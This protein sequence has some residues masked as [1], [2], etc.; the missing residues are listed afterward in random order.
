MDTKK[1][2]A[3]VVVIIVIVAAVA[4]Y[5]ALG[6]G[7]N[8]NDSSSDAHAIDL[9]GVEASE[10]NVLNGTYSISRNLVLVTDGEAT[11]NVAAFLSWIM[12]EEGQNILGEE[13]VKLT[14]FETEIE[15]SESGTTSIT[16]GGS[17]SLSE[18]AEKL[19]DA[20]MDKYPFMKISIQG[21]GSG[22]GES[23]C[24]SGEFQIG[25]LSRDLSAE[26]ASQGL[27]AHQIGQDGVAVIANVAGVDGLTTEQV[28]QIFSGEITNW[29][30]VGGPDQQIL[31]VI[32]E[33]GSGTRDCFDSA[34]EKIDEDF[35][36]TQN[37]VTCQSTGL[38]IQNVQNTAGSIGYI[39]IG[40]LANLNPQPETAE[41]HAL[42]LDGVEASEDNVLNGTYSISRNLVLVTDG[43]ATGNVAAFLS[44]IMSEEGQNILGEEFVKLTEFETEIEPSESGTTSITMGG[45]TSLSETA[46]KLAD[47]YMDKYPFMKISIQGGGS[48]VG[49]SSCLSGEFQ[50]G[51]LS[52][53]LSAEGASQGLIAHQ[54][55]QDGVAVI[56]NVA[57]VDGLT[58]EQVAQIFSGEI[59]NWNQV[60]GPDQ[61][62]LVVIR[63]DGSGT[64]DCFDSAMEKI[65][66]D[67]VCT[68]NAVTC[69][70][71]GLVIQN[72]Q[73][74][75][76]SIGYISI[77][78]LANL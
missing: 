1:I 67:F 47:A 70:S 55:G 5:M 62:I 41:A 32:R 77:G 2:A 4:A 37:A 10:D 53:D 59:T 78:Q 66:E 54:I 11:G 69:Q 14:E 50:I 34:M 12:S 15:P 29:N 42:D 74:T 27:I 25:M 71:T 13:F 30:Q 49:E 23:S 19:A 6:N 21:G 63:E 16:M 46:E 17:T 7:G 45:S 72:V 22:V 76:G 57:G 48:G 75:A 26:G 24:L 56:A 20:Y 31:V 65:D 9:D 73:N 33:D 43:E 18:T 8:D 39:S 68:Q 52:R 60:G 44:W 40:Q 35:V 58:T 36:C 28:A 3:I 38:V 64:R 51:M 61:Q